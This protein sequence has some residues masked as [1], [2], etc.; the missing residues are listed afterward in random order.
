M[1]TSHVAAGNPYHARLLAHARAPLHQRA[2]ARCDAAADGRN[3][4]CGDNIHIELE[5]HAGTIT[6]YAFRAEAC[7]L[8]VAA[9]SMLGQCVRGLDARALQALALDFDR[10]LAGTATTESRV[11]LGELAAFAELA[12]FPS[13]H[14]CARLP[15]ATALAA[16]QGRGCATTEEA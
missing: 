5:L 11:V 3:A 16:L 6:A 12:A 10:L 2:L 14:K 13:R 15:F 4:L 9:A 7:V 8:T 1:S